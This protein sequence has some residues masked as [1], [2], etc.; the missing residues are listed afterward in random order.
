HALL[1]RGYTSQ[2]SALMIKSN[3]DAKKPEHPFNVVKHVADYRKGLLFQGVVLSL[4]FILLALSLRRSRGAGPARWGFLIITVF[5]IQTNGPLALLPISGYPG[6]LQVF[7]ALLGL[8]SLAAIV[9]LFMPASLKYFRECKAVNR[10]EGA[11]VRPGLGS[12]FSSRGG[13]SG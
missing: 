9:L 3:N 10:P 6:A 1:A 12:L 11:P 7:R 2:L 8:S 5:V 4:A 13:A